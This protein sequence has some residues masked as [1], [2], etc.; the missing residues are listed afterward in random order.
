MVGIILALLAFA[1]VQIVVI[2]NSKTRRRRII[3][4]FKKD[5]EG[6]NLE[7]DEYEKAKAEA[8]AKAEEEA[9]QKSS[10]KEWQKQFKNKFKMFF[11]KIILVSLAFVS[12][13]ASAR[14]RADRRSFAIRGGGVGRSSGNRQFAAGGFAG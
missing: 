2:S 6:I 9:I 4:R 12:I 1:I 5:F 7:A 14:R 3:P 11:R 10:K 8:K 13:F